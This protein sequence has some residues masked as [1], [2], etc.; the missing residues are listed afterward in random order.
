MRPGT[1]PF[2]QKNS[3]QELV[4]SRCALN[5]LHVAGEVHL[6]MPVCI[7]GGQYIVIADNN[8]N[9]LTVTLPSV[10]S[11]A[12]LPSASEIPVPSKETLTQSKTH[13]RAYKLEEPLNIGD[14]LKLSFASE[15][16]VT[17]HKVQLVS[18]MLESSS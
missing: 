2:H 6:R 1:P 5:E 18:Q 10:S 7:S 16:P 15:A 3:V 4:G 9:N 17:V 12:S 14:M 11:F 8:L 13:T